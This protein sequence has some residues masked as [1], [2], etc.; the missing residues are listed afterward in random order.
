MSITSRCV[1]CS[2]GSATEKLDA[3]DVVSSIAIRLP[4][5]CDEFG[6]SRSRSSPAVVDAPLAGEGERWRTRMAKSPRSPLSPQAGGR[7]DAGCDVAVQTDHAAVRSPLLEREDAGHGGAAADRGIRASPCRRAA[8]RTSAPATGRGRCRDGA[9]RANGSRTN[10]TPCPSRR[11]GC[12]GPWSVTE[13]TTASLSRWAASVTVSPAGEKPTALASRLNSACRTRRSS[14]MKL[15]I[16]GGGA[17][18][19]LDAALAPGGPARPRRRPPWS[20]G[21]RPAPRLSVI[22]PASM[23]ARSRMLLMIASS[24]LVETVM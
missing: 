18:V 22:A 10:R 11:P 5:S 6:R 20:C 16:S 15:P 14:A 24:A 2:S 7:A 9:S 23:V 12:P 8:R 1:A 17:D 21:C 13:N 3:P 19:E 4:L